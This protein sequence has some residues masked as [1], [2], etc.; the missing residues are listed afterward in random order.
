MCTPL[1]GSEVDR[2]VDD[3]GHHRLRITAADAHG[4]LNAPHAGVGE[5]EPGVG[6]RRLKVLDEMRGLGHR[7]ENTHGESSRIVRC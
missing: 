5:G 2:A 3:R 4:L 7:Q 1:V 6:R